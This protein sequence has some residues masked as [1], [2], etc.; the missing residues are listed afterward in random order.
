[1]DELFRTRKASRRGLVNNELT[2][3]GEEDSTGA[4]DRALPLSRVLLR[5]MPSLGENEVSRPAQEQGKS[6]GRVEQ[7]HMWDLD[8][9]DEDTLIVVAAEEK[10]RL[11]REKTKEQ[12]KKDAELSGGIAVALAKL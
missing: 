11:E 12:S 1:V 4:V 7:F 2:Q 10:V 9:N 8:D 3:D 6:T 5:D